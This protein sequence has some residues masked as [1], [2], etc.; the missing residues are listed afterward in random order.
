MTKTYYTYK[1]GFGL[2]LKTSQHKTHG[3]LPWCVGVVFLQ[4][5]ELLLHSLPAFQTAPQPIRVDNVKVLA[6][7]CLTNLLGACVRS[8]W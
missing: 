3:S 2:R 5:V 8:E 1:S 4:W 6:A 7:L